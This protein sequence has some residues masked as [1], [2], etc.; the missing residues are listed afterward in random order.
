MIKIFK[1]G[2]HAH[3]TPLSYPALAPLFEG[4]TRLVKTP[5]EADLYVFAH[6]LDIE[7][8]PRALVEDWRLR[9]RPVVLL[10]EEPFW[11]TMWG[12]KPLTRNRVLDT[13]YG[14]LS[15][16]QLNHHTSDI[17]RFDRIPYYLLTNH[18]FA[19]TY[20]AHFARNASL[21]K[22]DWQARFAARHTDLT[23][24]FERR[25]EPYH[26]IRWPEGGIIGLCSWRTNLAE[27]CTRTSTGD[28]IERLGQ[29][30]QGGSSRFELD[31]WHLDKMT[32]LDDHTRILAAFENT[33]QPDYITEKLFDAFACG[34]LP[35]YFASPTH[36]IHDFDLPEMAWLN[37]FDLD[38]T[39]AAKRIADTRLTPEL[40]DAYAFSQTL[41]ARLFCDS[42]AWV[43]ERHRLRQAV[44]GALTRILDTA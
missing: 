20:A 35:L 8:A 34:A 13:R 6:S 33:H 36:R 22:A 44:L 4:V 11:D 25:P 15:V 12:R 29:S 30:W 27:I 31:N 28:I 40:F 7:A 14:A 16:I 10:S 2:V 17:F 18:R 3:R 24:M 37:L 21:T 1:Y 43:D 26:T 23:F 5:Q 32:R 38:V 41:L 19:N 39:N 9:R 42:A